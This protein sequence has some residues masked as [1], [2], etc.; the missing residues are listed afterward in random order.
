MYDERSTFSFDVVIKETH[1]F[2]EEDIHFYHVSNNVTFNCYKRE[3][4]SLF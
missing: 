4:I 3:I 2:T 1:F